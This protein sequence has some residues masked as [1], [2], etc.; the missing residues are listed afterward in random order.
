MSWISTITIALT[1]SIMMVSVGAGAS[2]RLEIPVHAGVANE[3]L[4]YLRSSRPGEKIKLQQLLLPSPGAEIVDIELTRFEIFSPDAA[5]FV[6]S[7][8]GTEKVGMPQTHHF[9]GK[10]KD[11]ANSSAFFSIDE[12]GKLRGIINRG[13]GTFLTEMPRADNNLSTPPRTSKVDELTAQNNRE[14]SCGTNQSLVEA[15]P[16]LSPSFNSSTQGEETENTGQNTGSASASSIWKAG[17]II[18]TDYEFFQIF[19]DINAAAIYV[20][21]LVAYANFAYQEEIDTR[22]EI[23][24]IYLYASSNDPWMAT[25]TVA[26]LF[27]LRDYW[28]SP[29]RLGQYRQHVHLVS[30]KP[31]GGGV[32]YVDTLC[33]NA[34]QFAYGVSAVFGNFSVDNPQIVWDSTIVAHELGHA[35]GSSHTHD[36]DNPHIGV[37][38]NAI[39]CCY[40]SATERECF[41]ITGMSGPTNLL[42]GFGTSTGGSQGQ[43]GG[44]IMSYC[45]MSTGGFDNVS[46][47]FGKNHSF[48]YE[49]QRV[50]D[51]M[52]SRASACLPLD[53]TSES[54][55]FTLTAA[56]SG[57][58]YLFSSPAGIDCGTECSAV[59][60]AGTAVRLSAQADAGSI[61][62]GWSGACS[63]SGCNLD[64]DGPKSV[65][66]TFS[67]G[68]ENASSVQTSGVAGSEQQYFLDVPEGARN[69]FI[70]ISGGSG[71]ADLYMRYLSVPT[72]EDYHCR[73]FLAGNN[74]TCFQA[75]APAGRYHVML[76]G[77]SDE[78]VNLTV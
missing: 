62:L 72:L 27:E 12:E 36:F 48:G 69:L 76:H 49:P 77:W 31:M 55:L 73:P 53:T 14:F 51:A 63:G 34:I 61:F 29:S 52:R 65:L 67:K 66:A 59:F 42:P 11:E 26:A 13:D 18:E 9:F 33:G 44:G 23:E 28:N 8:K 4:Q 30:G 2:P 24:A 46:M 5:V 3:Q 50:A 7:Q 19:N 60:E 75:S 17:L 6:T 1:A 32:A 70:Q 15:Q 78:G 22:L 41:A 20:A 21:D 43:G 57:E 10:I 37:G 47:T 25:D 58:G 74:E 45:H 39:D 40:T 16:Q 56:S 64:M 38:G 35:F 71:D 54:A 68:L